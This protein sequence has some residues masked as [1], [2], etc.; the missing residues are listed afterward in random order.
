MTPSSRPLLWE[1]RDLCRAPGSCRS[2]GKF[3]SPFVLWLLKRKCVGSSTSYYV[4]HRDSLVCKTGIL[5]Q[6]KKIGHF[7]FNVLSSTKKCAKQIFWFHSWHPNFILEPQKFGSHKWSPDGYF[8][9]LLF[10]IKWLTSMVTS[11]LLPS[12]LHHLEYYFIIL[13]N[14]LPSLTQHHIPNRKVFS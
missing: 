7:T 10:K 8:T 5:T 2:L 1:L 12:L 4:T 14:T 6:I 3:M 13:H 9:L 11:K